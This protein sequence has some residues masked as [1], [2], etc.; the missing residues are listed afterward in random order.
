MPWDNS[1]RS[2]ELPPH[3]A[4]LRAACKE[5][6]GGQCQATLRDSTRCPEQGNEAHHP[7]RNDHTTLVWLCPWH[8]MRIT[9]QQAATARTP[10]TERKPKGKHPGMR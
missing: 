10:I 7:D 9:Q 8:H 5:A 2:K 6:A 3:W 4:K 1:P